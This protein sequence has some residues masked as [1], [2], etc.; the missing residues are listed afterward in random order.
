MAERKSS[1]GVVAGVVGGVV[2]RVRA[3]VERRQAIPDPPI[4]ADR[5]G[6]PPGQWRA[7]GLED[8]LGLPPGCPVHPLGVDGQTFHFIDDIGQLF[9]VPEGRQFGQDVIQRLFGSRPNYL[10]WAWPKISPPKKEGESFSVTSWRAELVRQDLFQACKLKGPWNSVERIRGRGAWTTKDGR[11][12]LHCGDALYMGVERIDTGEH[13]E[14][15][16]PRRPSI[17]HPFA[18]PV[19]DD[20]SPGLKL[21][22]ILRTWS[23]ER[24]DVDP[25]LVVG[26]IVV[27]MIGGALEWRPSIFLVGD[28][29]T[30]KS[31][32]QRLIKAVLG[33]ML[34]QA[35]DTT[36]AGIYQR[37]GTDA[38]PVA[39]DEL[40]AGADNKRVIGVVNL[41][42]LSASGGLMLRGGQDNTGTEFQARSPF[43]FSAIVAP[44]LPPQD[45]SRLGVLTLKRLDP[46]KIAS[47]PVLEA[48]DTIGPRI[49][50]RLVDRW[51]QWPQLLHAYKAALFKGKHDTRGQDTYGTLL[52]AAHLLL[53]D[54]AMAE[55]G[56]NAIEKW[57]DL[58]GVDAL[59]DHVQREDNWRKCIM[60]ILTSRVPAWRH[61]ARQTI[62]QL[63]EDVLETSRLKM[64]GGVNME[65]AV[66]LM[67]QAGLGLHRDPD[68]SHGLILSVPNN[69]P[70]L[71]ELFDGSVWAGAAGVGGWAGSLRQGPPEI[72]VT[73]KKKNN[74]KIG[75]V[76]QRCTLVK[77]DDFFKLME[78]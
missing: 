39:V 56:V 14:F 66:R 41:A 21:V 70:L 65:E 38:L 57:A 48:A 16:Y 24:P 49:L 8:D 37:I 55:A 11:L 76:Q 22:E 50:R 59:P 1:A 18:R 26:W 35:T 3:R 10:Y 54:D 23:W 34:V 77:L 47:P 52:A 5:D 9:S 25:L 6:I 29:G 45:L 68:L 30:G 36:P 69:S 71:A 4:G 20:A 53:G 42:R 33:G 60:H 51:D 2:D 32:L 15:F 62:G 27:A 17:A 75:G 67:A 78:G 58:L 73:D 19:D 46:E 31:H 13:G 64:D 72:V 28:A 7:R 44:P 43:L 61:G 12:V 74:R 63:V 40:E